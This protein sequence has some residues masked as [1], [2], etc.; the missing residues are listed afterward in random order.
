MYFLFLCQGQ[1]TSFDL[2]SQTI[3]TNC[4]LGLLK[5]F[6]I[7][8]VKLASVAPCP[9]LAAGLTFDGCGLRINSVTESQKCA[10]LSLFWSLLDTC[11]DTW[12]LVCGVRSTLR[13][14]QNKATTI[15]TIYIYIHTGIVCIKSFWYKDKKIIRKEPPGC[16][17]MHQVDLFLF[18]S[19]YKPMI[20]PAHT[21]SDPQFVYCCYFSPPQ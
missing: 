11:L 17:K 21:V 16:C 1:S 4:K 14:A 12:D 5:K 20:G 13:K 6:L 3:S 9:G 2:G 8:F 15:T 19:K 7:W 10:R 18:Q